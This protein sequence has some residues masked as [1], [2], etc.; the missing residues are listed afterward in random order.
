MLTHRLQLLLDEERYERISA[1]ARQRQTSVA[2]VIREAIDR[3][4]PA[5][6]RRRAA[7]AKRILTAE[8]SAVGN[9]EDLIVELNELRGR[10]G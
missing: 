7:A 6:P 10:R 3:G 2:A 4:L 1:L 8:P 9:V 5:T